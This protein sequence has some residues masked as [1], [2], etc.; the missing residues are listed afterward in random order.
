MLKS[1]FFKTIC[2]AVALILLMSAAA[3]CTGN[4]GATPTPKVVTTPKITVTPG[5][6]VKPAVSPTV[7]PTVAPSPSTGASASPNA[8]G[9]KEGSAAK[10]E[11][12]SVL[13]SDGS[14]PKID[15]YIVEEK[16]V[17]S[18]GIEEYVMGVVAGEVHNDWPIETL[19]AQA[20]IARTYVVD[21]VKEKGKSEYADALISTDIKEAQAWDSKDINENVK[22]AVTETAGLVL[23]YDGEFAK[24]W[25]HSSSGGKTATSKEGLNYKYDNPPYIKVID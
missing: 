21:F 16:K 6:T 18:M 8:T 14:A 4:T 10:P 12:P 5:A 13:S 17:Q 11:L 3:G 22:K 24:T 7:N 19:K 20:I 2:I 25:F 15:V 23:A 9:S 1:K